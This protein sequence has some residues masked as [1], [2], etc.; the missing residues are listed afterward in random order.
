MCRYGDSAHLLEICCK[1]DELRT[2]QRTL[3]AGG[4]RGRTALERLCQRL[5]QQQ[6]TVPAN[7][8]AAVQQQDAVASLSM[9]ARLQF[10]QRSHLALGR[11][12]EAGV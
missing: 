11:P 12:E 4:P 9:E 2:L 10:V 8:S 1:H 7:D 3:A 6:D 5:W